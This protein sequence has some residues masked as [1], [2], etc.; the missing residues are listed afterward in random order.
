MSLHFFDVILFMSLDI[1]YLLSFSVIPWYKDQCIMFFDNQSIITLRENKESAFIFFF[2][3]FLFVTGI[4]CLSCCCDCTESSAKQT[5]SLLAVEG[6]SLSP[7]S[8]PDCLR[9]FSSKHYH[10]LQWQRDCCSLICLAVVQVMQLLAV[11]E[12]PQGR[13]K[14]GRMTEK[15]KEERGK[16]NNSQ[17]NERLFPASSETGFFYRSSS[18]ECMGISSCLQAVFGL[19]QEACLGK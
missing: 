16:D 13:R 19:I 1:K 4:R 9:L 14:G 11:N 6:K 8:C 15:K 2:F 7:A 5:I 10:R 3:F 18:M 17:E 12:A